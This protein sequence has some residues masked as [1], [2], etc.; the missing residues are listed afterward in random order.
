MAATSVKLS[1]QLKQ[2]IA[3]L[4]AGTGQTAH[5][6]MLEAIEPAAERAILRARFGSEALEAEAETL[7]TGKAYVASEVFDYLAAKARGEKV[8]RPRAKAW[9]P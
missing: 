4:V 3:E 9:R 1:D 6:F 5:A 2:R 8:N 7:R